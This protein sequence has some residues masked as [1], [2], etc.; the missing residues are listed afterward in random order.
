MAKQYPNRSDL[1]NPA[2]KMA[3]KAAPGQTYG[4]A[5]KQV[6]AQRAVPM[7]APPTDVAPT[8][9]PQQPR[10]APGSMG[11]LSRPTER[12]NEP[13]TAGA[14]FGPGRTQQLGGY[15]G[16]RN[17]DPILDELRALYATYPSEELADML[18]SYIREGY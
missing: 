14:P 10:V 13:L 12:P 8:A 2:K 1:R 15:I 3:A 17:S 5:G 4:E 11:P 18:D 9:T 7:A 6:A 16:P